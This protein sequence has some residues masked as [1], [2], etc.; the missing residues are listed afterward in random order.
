M[1]DDALANAMNFGIERLLHDERPFMLALREPRAPMLV[2]ES[3][4][5]PRP[6]SVALGNGDRGFRVW[7]S[8]VWHRASL[9][10]D[11]GWRRRD[12]S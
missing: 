12:A 4:R 7:A 8:G 2:R 6:P 1:D 5:E 3:E 9:M 11:A 10:H